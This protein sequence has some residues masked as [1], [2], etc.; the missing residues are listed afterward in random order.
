M[1]ISAWLILTVFLTK[2]LFSQVE[3]PSREIDLI[4]GQKIPMRDGIELNATIY[5]PRSTER[6][7]VIFT[8]T[9][10]IADTYHDRAYYFSKQEFVFVVVDTRGRGNSG[11]Q[12]TPFL[13]EAKDGHDIVKWLAKQPWSNGRVAMWGG[14]YAGYNQWVTAKEFPSELKTIVPAASVMPTIDFPFCKN[15]TYPYVIQ[16]ITWT[17]GMTPNT[18]LF[19]E[20]SFWVEKFSQ[21]YYEHRPFKELDRIIGNP[22][23]T[24][25]TWIAHSTLDSFWEAYI[26]TNDQ[27]GRISIPILSITGHYDV[28]QAGALEFYKRHLRFASKDAKDRHYLIIGPWDHPGTRTPK[29]EFGGLNFGEASMLDMNSLHKEWYD[30]VLKS[31]DKPRFLKNNVAYYVSGKEEWKYAESLDAIGSTKKILFLDS[32]AGRAHDAFHSGLL[33][34]A[35]PTNSESDNYTYDPLDIRP[36][37]LEKQDIEN[38]FTDERYALNLYGNGLIYHSD[39]LT[40]EMEISG[41]V[42]LVLW[43]SLDVVDTD[44]SVSIYEIMPNGRSV[45]LTGDLIRARFRDSL[46]IEKLVKPGEVLRYD[47]NGFNWFS[48]RI[49][50][51]S[52]IRLTISCPNSIFSQKNY[53]SGKKV[54][55]ETGKDAKTAHITLYHDLNYQSY[56]ELPIG[57]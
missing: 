33:N 38:Y 29:R 12:F 57:K 52:R 21:L 44:F 15:I 27:F 11:G 56:L 2:N 39:P 24:F 13:Q 47:F 23:T 51:G 10:Y 37:E 1:K 46:R 55:E 20:S 16:W 14:S 18:K 36:A 49:S 17:S 7:P 54:H 43:M 41:Y 9:P 3:V 50:K 30:W 8:L 34:E 35:K 48:R 31:S 6:L 28:D 26:P 53:N 42:K 22:S 40:D 32:D 45:Y 4:W 25:Q 19:N 5:K